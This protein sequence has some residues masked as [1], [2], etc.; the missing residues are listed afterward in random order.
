MAM[1]PPGNRQDE[2]TPMITAKA[3]KES[4]QSARARP[5]RMFLS[6]S[7]LHR[8]SEDARAAE[9]LAG[10]LEPYLKELHI[11]LACAR[12]ALIIFCRDRGIA[13]EIRFLQ[14]EILKVLAA[15]GYGHLQVVR[16]RLAATP[17][18]STMRQPAR[19]EREMTEETRRLI[20]STALQIEDA[21][22]RQAL[23]RLAGTKSV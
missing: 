16:I 18:A 3:N 14:R 22:L 9:A 12:D 17:A 6:A 21:R 23:T 15:T 20:R 8:S 1:K 10:L 2:S 13:T 11:R 4:S 19:V 7:V 5:I